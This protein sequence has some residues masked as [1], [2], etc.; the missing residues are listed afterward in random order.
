ML[1]V[2]HDSSF[3]SNQFFAL[4]LDGWFDLFHNRSFF[5]FFFFDIPFLCYYINLKLSIILLFFSGDIYL[6]FAT[7]LCS[8]SPPTI[9]KLFCGELFEIFT[10]LSVIYLTIK[11]PVAFVAF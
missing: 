10:I 11:S 2:A 5:F 6:R 3:I 9:S 4:S 7:Y 1:H 8:A